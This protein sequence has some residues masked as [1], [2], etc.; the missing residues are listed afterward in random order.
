MRSCPVLS[1]TPTLVLAAALS[2]ACAPI[3]YRTTCAP[4]PP[5]SFEAVA[6][7]PFQLDF[8]HRYHEAYGKTENLLQALR[9]RIGDI[10]LV[11][12][13]EFKVTDPAAPPR[14]GS[15]IIQSA[16]ALG[17]APDRIVVL[18]ANARREEH[19]HRV[20]VRDFF[21]KPTGYL[22]AWY[23]VYR[24]TLEL[25]TLDGAVLA[26]TMGEAW[27]RRGDMAAAPAEE[28]FPKLREAI[29]L[30]LRDLHAAAAPAVR[31]ARR[32]VRTDIQVL[33]THQRLLRHPEVWID[34]SR[35]GSVERDVAE[36]VRYEYF[37]AGLPAAWLP[38]LRESG[39][40]VVVLKVRGAAA[41]SGLR[42]GDIIT[43]ADGTAVR[44]AASF[45]RALARGAR[46]LTARRRGDPIT[47]ALAPPC[48]RPSPAVLMA[49]VGAPERP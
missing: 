49:T 26:R 17:F 25:V 31:L 34:L 21:G 9:E 2:G 1:L 29:P 24:V 37:V 44:G 14:T 33:D 11:G 28:P 12:P 6:V 36:L 40:G 30:L 18:R 4:G 10:T 3:A 42:P 45:A 22:H 13:E 16:R 43:G 38:A 20:L 47:V 32:P 15:S 23:A 35:A 46:V 5:R 7:Y 27:E 39:D 19:N 41:A 48:S 8:T